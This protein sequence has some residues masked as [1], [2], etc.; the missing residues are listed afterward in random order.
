MIEVNVLKNQLIITDLEPIT[1]G[2]VNV[3]KVHFHFSSDWDGLE[4]IAVFQTQTT[5]INIPIQD[6]IAII[7]WEVM[8]TPNVAIRLGVYGIK[9]LTTILPTI[10]TDLGVVVEGV[11]IG[12]AESAGHSPD[13]YEA[14]LRKFEEI[15]EAIQN[16]NNEVRS[17]DDIYGLIE[18]YFEEHPPGISNTAI[19]TAINNYFNN[20]PIHSLTREEVQQMIDQS[21]GAAISSGY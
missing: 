19:E 12:D 4:R 21:V 1:S 6:D 11:I 10:W 16:L 2:S 13:I 17:D 18:E 9:T 20:H 5:T 7:P 3:Y 8:T 15:D 14:I